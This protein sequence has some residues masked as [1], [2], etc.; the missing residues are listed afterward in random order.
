MSVKRHCDHGNS[1]NPKHL[2]CSGLQFQGI[3]LLSPWWKAWWHIDVKGPALSS[4]GVLKKECM[5]MIKQIMWSQILGYKLLANILHKTTFPCYS[6]ISLNSSS[7]ENQKHMLIFT[8]KFSHY[9]RIPSRLYNESASQ[10]ISLL[11]L[12]KRQAYM[13]VCVCVYNCKRFQRLSCFW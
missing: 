12:R 2:T 5:K 4:R 9:T 10:D 3:S 13:C 6:K 7:L 1:Y 11:I 8:Y